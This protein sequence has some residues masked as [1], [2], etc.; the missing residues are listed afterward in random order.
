MR[1]ASNL[2][3][4][5]FPV[6]LVTAQVLCNILYLI[7]KPLYIS[8]CFYLNWAFG[9]GAWVSFIMLL[10]TFR[11]RLCFVS[12][13]AA[14]AECI[15]ALWYIIFQKDDIYNIVMQITVGGI[16]IM[17]TLRAIYKKHPLC[18]FS[19]LV[20]FLN[21]LFKENG[22]CYQAVERWDNK[23]IEEV[24]NKNLSAYR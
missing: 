20:E 19:L 21:S 15:F 17:W 14:I 5:L 4:S 23:V 12:R 1:K 22:N 24:K 2:L 9:N 7:D 8:K 3:I 18:S 6:I 11:L 16:A 13:A 10:F